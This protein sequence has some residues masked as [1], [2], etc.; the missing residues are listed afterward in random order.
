[1]ADVRKQIKF[2]ASL[3]GFDKLIQE[4]KQ[5]GGELVVD[6]DV[7]FSGK[8]LE[9]FK[10][11]LRNVANQAQQIGGG[12]MAAGTI[13]DSSGRPAN[14]ISSPG[15][16]PT[17]PQPGVTGP[18]TYSSRYQQLR[19]D[20]SYNILQSQ[21]EIDRR[22]D[23]ITRMTGAGAGAG[24]AFIASQISS[25]Q[26]RLGGVSGDEK[27]RMQSMIAGMQ[28]L[29]QKFKDLG[30]ELDDVRKKSAE[31]A[32]QLGRSENV[33]AAR[34]ELATLKKREADILEAQ[35]A[36]LT[37]AGAED[38]AGG[39]GGAALA[40]RIT[41]ALAGATMLGMFRSLASSLFMGPME[42][43]H[44]AGEVGKTYG[45]GTRAMMNITTRDMFTWLDPRATGTAGVAANMSATG[46]RLLGAGAAMAGGGAAGTMLGADIGQY[47]GSGGIGASIGAVGGAASFL[48]LYALRENKFEM[49]KRRRAQFTRQAMDSIGSARDPIIALA[50]Q[51]RERMGMRR[52]SLEAY[53]VNLF[54]PDY[55]NYV[56]TVER[57]G[58]GGLSGFKEQQMLGV[59][60]QMQML[61]GGFAG[62]TGAGQRAMRL[63]RATGLAPDVIGGQA[64]RM[65]G[66]GNAGESMSKLEDMYARAVERG[67]DNSS[68]QRASVDAILGLGTQLGGLLGFTSG[69][70][71]FADV[72][73]S[74]GLDEGLQ[75]GI[76]TAFG[77]QAMQRARQ[78]GGFQ[79]FLGIVGAQRAI[80]Q[81]G[82]GGNRAGLAMAL[83]GFTGSELQDL[84][85]DSPLLERLRSISG[86]PDLTSA[87]AALLGQNLLKQQSQLQ[88]QVSGALYGF[89]GKGAN[90]QFQRN[91]ARMMAP[92]TGDALARAEFGAAAGEFKKNEWFK[93]KAGKF[94]LE[95]QATANL[96]NVATALDELTE[97]AQI[98]AGQLG[99]GAL[100]KRTEELQASM[101]GTAEEVGN[102]I[103]V[104]AQ[105][106]EDALPTSLKHTTTNT[107]ELSDALKVLNGVMADSSILS[108]QAL[109]GAFR[110]IISPTLTGKA[111]KEFDALM[112]RIERSLDPPKPRKT[113]PRGVP[114]GGIPATSKI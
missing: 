45:Q 2:V 56:N 63:A 34:A 21:V 97:R 10:D 84:K 80:A 105:G 108:K 107:Q 111:K 23:A 6:I 59:M 24:Q 66:F 61:G 12:G 43:L 90:A 112:D 98:G 27:T 22:Q 58:L 55:A 62:A 11:E 48:G 113:K 88:L 38:A 33:E 75:P 78:R 16:S 51:A 15:S 95:D 37:G 49:N 64:G 74:T 42:R 96:Q 69:A 83:R 28:G 104:L 91:I 41:K 71:M 82:I 8:T 53:G 110:E 76:A 99:M 109:V 60:N 93:T 65:V 72:A 87:Q 18:G 57:E 29:L 44:T 106:A 26:G 79:G 7:R 68:L 100:V 32:D 77:S 103:A 9:G 20:P 50:Q 5:I 81:S 52:G 114:K 14:V 13:L 89:T 85:E 3:E 25:A 102:L 101:G 30:E 94:K 86:L 46:E 31:L 19:H 36:T 35:G 4:I 70:E 40:R 17:G 1:M 39:G 47:F 54:S 73:A 67:M 92:G